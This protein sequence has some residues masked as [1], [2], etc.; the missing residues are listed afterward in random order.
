MINRIS[1]NKIGP[2]YVRRIL[3]VI[4]LF[5]DHNSCLCAVQRSYCIFLYTSI[6]LFL[7][8]VRSWWQLG[9]DIWAATWQN[10]Q[11]DCAP[12]EDSDQ[13]GHPP[14]LIKVF[15]VCMKKAWVLGY[16]LSAQRRLIRLGRFLSFFPRTI[17]TWNGLTTEAVSAE[18]VDGFKSKI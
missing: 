6:E 1:C 17:A 3:F 9:S 16:K 13:P 12:S 8:L 11:S 5:K 4:L 15:A 18:T 7:N 2:L 14:S 10:Q